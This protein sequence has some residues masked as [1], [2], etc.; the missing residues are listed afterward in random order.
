[1]GCFMALSEMQKQ[2]FIGV[3]GSLKM[4]GSWGSFFP[5]IRLVRHWQRTLFIGQTIEENVVFSQCYPYDFFTALIDQYLAFPVETDSV[6]ITPPTP[7]PRSF[8]PS[9]AP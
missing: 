6:H 7:K 5:E 4:F 1:M 8:L 3:C 2:R 9:Y